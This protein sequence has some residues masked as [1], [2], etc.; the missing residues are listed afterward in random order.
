MIYIL[1]RTE[2]GDDGIFGNLAGPDGSVL[3]VTCEPPNSGPHP[4]IPEGTYVVIPHDSPAHPQTWEIT[5][6]PNRTAILIHDGN[7]EHDTLGCICVGDRM[8]WI[9]GLRAV[10]DSKITLKT[11]RAEL[12]SSFTLTIQEHLAD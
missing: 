4:C 5:D 1:T 11:L 6:V 9:N 10:L 7:T 3:C 8:G 2:Q 12:P